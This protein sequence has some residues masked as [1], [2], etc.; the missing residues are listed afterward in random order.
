MLKFK[1]TQMRMA[2]YDGTTK[3][4]K[5]GYVAFKGE[6][7]IRVKPLTHSKNTQFALETCEEIIPATWDNDGRFIP[8]VWDKKEYG[9]FATSKEAME[10]AQGIFA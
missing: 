10:A 5:L 3:G 7:H 2:E 6:L 8:A 1:R 9:V 4:S